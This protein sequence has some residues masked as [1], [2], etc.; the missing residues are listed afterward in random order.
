MMRTK[1]Q[2]PSTPFDF[3]FPE[4]VIVQKHKPNQPKIQISQP[5]K[6]SQLG[7]QKQSS[8]LQSRNQQKPQQPTEEQPVSYN[9]SQKEII[10]QQV[11]QLEMYCKIF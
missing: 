3:E 8:P 5:S 6:S 9:E 2:D 11:E 7:H 10:N 4:I 1:Q